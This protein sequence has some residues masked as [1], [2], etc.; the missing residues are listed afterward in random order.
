MA[1][2]VVAVAASFAWIAALTADAA[3]DARRARLITLEILLAEKRALVTQSWAR[4]AEIETQI[5]EWTTADSQV[6]QNP[7]SRGA[8]QAQALLKNAEKREMAERERYLVLRQIAGWYNEMALMRQEAERT[9]AELQED[10]QVL[11]GRWALSMLPMGIKGDVILTQNGT[12]VTGDYRFENGQA[13]SVQGTFV[14]NILVLERIDARYG[15]MGR[16]EGTLSRDRQSVKGSWYSYD[17]TSGQPL[18][19]AFALERPGEE[20]GS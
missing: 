4:L 18:T 20:G 12:L 5:Q 3:R 11:D 8:D 2:V 7:D 15:R 19:G 17:V 9:R 16:L 13:G 14:N 1:S 10:L 6:L